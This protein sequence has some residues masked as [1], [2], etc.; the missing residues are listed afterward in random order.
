MGWGEIGGQLLT[1]GTV[2]EALPSFG[3]VTFAQ[4]KTDLMQHASSIDDVIA[5]NNLPATDPTGGGLIDL[6]SAQGRA[7]G[8]LPANSTATDGAIGFSATAPWDFN[9]TA[10]ISPGQYD[11][12]GTA[13]HEITH[14]L[15]RV[16]GSQIVASATDLLDL[17]RYSAP[18]NLHVAPGQPSYFSIDGGRTDLHNFATSGDLSDWSNSVPPDANDNNATPGQVNPFTLIDFNEMDVLGFS[19]TL[20][21]A[22]NVALPAPATYQS[23]YGSEPSSTE[24]WKLKEFDSAQSIYAQTIWIQDAVVYMY[25]ALGQ[26]LAGKSDTGS[27]AFNSTWGP[28]TISSDAAFS[29]QAYAHV[30]GHQGTQAQD[31]HFID[32]LNFYNTLY[33]TSGAYGT[34]ANL[35]DLLARGAIY[36][37]MLG[38]R[39]EL[40]VATQ[41]ATQTVTSAPTDTQLVGVSSQHDMTHHFV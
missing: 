9:S 3:G 29:A 7:L 17:F 2:G 21:L 39:A 25:S 36:G 41:V 40:A 16:L 38:V 15:G 32:Q 18:G 23:M 6:S 12:L 28:L 5:I 31:Q 1:P 34:D 13:W 26:A 22:N 10:G 20:P 35:I 14:A 37:Q 4:L 24:L 30:F 8:I 11:F 27:T 19:L 33:K